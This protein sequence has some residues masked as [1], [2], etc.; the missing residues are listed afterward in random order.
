[1]Q[2]VASSTSAGSLVVEELILPPPA[3][4]PPPPPRWPCEHQRGYSPLRCSAF[5]QELKHHPNKAWVTRLLHGMDFG[6]STGYKGPHLPYQAHN[7]AS[8]LAHPEAVDAELD[9][10]VQAGRVLGPFSLRPSGNLRTSGLGVVPKM[11][12]KWRVILHLSAP[13]GH[14][15]N[16]FISREEFTLHYSTID[17]AVAL[18]S[19]FNRGALMAKLDLQAAFRMVPVLSGSSWECTGVVNIMWTLASPLA[20]ARSPASSITLPP[21]CTGSWSTT[22]ELPSY[23]TLTTF[24]CLVHPVR[25]PASIPCPPCC[26]YAR[27]WACRSPWRSPRTS[28]LPNLPGH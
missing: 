25:P 15:I 17:D 23:T 18:L 2:T 11:N 4:P 7:L 16:D 21:P 24:S 12:G 8:A 9:K 6:V 1:M 19:M 14:N 5:E 20:Y 3:P 22:M 27:N 26:E 28:H 13:E 10:E